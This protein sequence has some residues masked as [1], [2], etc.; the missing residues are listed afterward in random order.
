MQCINKTHGQGINRRLLHQDG[1]NCPS[2][3][4][5]FFDSVVM[6]IFLRFKKKFIFI[7]LEDNYFTIWCWFI[8]PIFKV[9][10][11]MFNL[12][13]LDSTSISI[14]NPVEKDGSED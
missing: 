2:I 4:P 8:M 7:H 12:F 3:S 11:S 1:S 13:F 9:L 10:F 14:S 5:E 6:A